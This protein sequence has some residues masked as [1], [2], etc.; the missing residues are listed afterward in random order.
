[1]NK[2]EAIQQHDRRTASAWYDRAA[3]AR[4][5]SVQPAYPRGIQ[6]VR[7]GDIIVFDTEGG[8]IAQYKRPNSVQIVELP[9]ARSNDF[10]TQFRAQLPSRPAAIIIDSL[11][12]NMNPISNA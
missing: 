1:M 10:L 7:G 6:S 2:F 8:R 9:R 11:P 3:W 4:K 5:N 12:M